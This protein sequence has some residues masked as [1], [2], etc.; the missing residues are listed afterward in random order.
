MERNR[1]YAIRLPILG[2]LGKMRKKLFLIE[3]AGILKRDHC[4]AD[5]FV[6]LER[7]KEAVHSV[8]ITGIGNEQQLI[9]AFAADSVFVHDRFSAAGQAFQMLREEKV[10]YKAFNPVKKAHVTASFLSMRN[11]LSEV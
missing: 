8:D 4:A 5:G 2:D 6:I 10:E 7:R 1:H 11:C 9:F 3:R